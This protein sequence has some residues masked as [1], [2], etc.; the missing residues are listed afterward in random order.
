MLRPNKKV[1]GASLYRFFYRL[2]SAL[3]LLATMLKLT[4]RHIQCDPKLEAGF[5]MFQSKQ[6]LEASDFTTI[7]MFIISSHCS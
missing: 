1:V 4:T 5:R 2:A 6:Y 3:L 7:A